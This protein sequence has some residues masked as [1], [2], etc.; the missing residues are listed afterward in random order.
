M[1]AL[2]QNNLFVPE[3]KLTERLLTTVPSTSLHTKQIFSLSSIWYHA[4]FNILT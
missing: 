3:Q 1:K 2:Q 4:L